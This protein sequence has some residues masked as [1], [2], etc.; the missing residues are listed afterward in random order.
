MLAHL[1]AQDRAMLHPQKKS[2]AWRSSTSSG[3]PMLCKRSPVIFYSYD[4]IAH[5]NASKRLLDANSA[6]VL[7][8]EQEAARSVHRFP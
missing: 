5:R 1:L 8:S 7:R 2:V 6:F 4:S 3:L